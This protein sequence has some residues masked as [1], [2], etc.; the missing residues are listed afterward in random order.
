MG[1]GGVE[2]QP[3]MFRKN[4]G[5]DRRTN[6]NPE[7]QTGAGEDTAAFPLEEAALIRLLSRISSDRSAPPAYSP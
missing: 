4:G 5:S 7:G 6:T 2:T 3:D 1:S